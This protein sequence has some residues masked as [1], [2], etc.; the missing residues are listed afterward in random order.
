MIFLLFGIHTKVKQLG[1]AAVRACPRCHNTTPWERVRCQEELTIFF[2][3]ILR[4]SRRELEVC[5]VC[6]SATEV[7]RRQSAPSPRTSHATA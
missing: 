3:P 5:P 1:G 4:W 6:G 7:P 2:V